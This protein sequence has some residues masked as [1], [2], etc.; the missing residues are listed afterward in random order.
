MGDAAETE[1]IFVQG[2][3]FDA[4]PAIPTMQDAWTRLAAMLMFGR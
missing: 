1:L 2:A 4:S 3:A